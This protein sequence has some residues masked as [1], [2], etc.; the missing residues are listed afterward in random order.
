MVSDLTG[1]DVANAS[2]LD[3]GTSAAEA[4]ALTHRFTRRKKI[5]VSDKVHPQ[6]ISVIATRMASLGLELEVG[7]VYKLNTSAKN[8]AGILVQYPDTTGSI[9]DFSEV[10][11]EAHSNGVSFPLQIVTLGSFLLTICH[12]Y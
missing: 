1:L 6:S 7:D 9:T 11:K 2:L 12:F 3:E 10:V 5:F 8:V 4:L